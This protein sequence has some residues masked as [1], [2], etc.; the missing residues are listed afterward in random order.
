MLGMAETN[1]SNTSP[2]RSV[3]ATLTEGARFPR[4]MCN[5]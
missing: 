1:I 2:K 3:A 5:L 4:E